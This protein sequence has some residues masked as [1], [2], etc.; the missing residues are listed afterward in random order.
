M[1]VDVGSFLASAERELGARWV[2]STSATRH[3]YGSSEL[4][5]G[6]C[7]PAAVLYPGSTADVRAVVALANEHRVALH[8]ISTGRNIGLGRAVAS[9]AG[10]VIVDLGRRMNRILELDERLNFVVVE[11]GVTYR[12]L[13]DELVRRGDFLMCDTTSGP[14]DGGPLGNTLDKGAGYTPA[15]D[16]FGNACGLEVVL[17]DGR[18][19]RTGDGALPGSK[20]WHLARYGLGPFLD[21][22][23]LQSN[24]GI[25]TRMGIWLVPRPPVIRSFFFIFDDDDDIEHIFEAVRPLRLGGVV[26]TAIKATNDLYCLASQIPYPA[27]SAPI[28]QDLRRELHKAHG[29]GAWI[30]SGALYGPSEAAVAPVL[31]HVITQFTSAGAARYI[32]HEEA[33]GNPKFQVH[34]DT[35]SGR[36]T[37][38]EVKMVNW[39][40]GGFVSLTPATP[41]IGSVAR[42]HQ[43]MSREILQRHGMDTCIDYICAGRTARGLHSIAFDSAS[44]DERQSASDACRELRH[45]YAAAGYPIGRAPADMQADEM[46]LRDP[47]FRQTL[48][49]IKAVL[50]PRGI[51]SPGRYGIA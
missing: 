30:V 14:P 35:Y 51:L 22:L 2:D 9:S 33:A 15:A 13:H 21:G 27:D 17:G 26:P 37:A 46:S 4:P 40:R 18:V 38:E 49:G 1:S 3:R 31:E 11:P 36:P 44:A 19:L 25:V 5:A 41:L 47:E 29:I 48:S 20:T 43:R 50:D 32:P 45:A 23:F 42:Q 7:L 28:G 8:P 34:I 6:D 12:Q 39:R 24:L 16:H 10:M